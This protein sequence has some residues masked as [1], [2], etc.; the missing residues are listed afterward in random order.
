MTG[1]N[2]FG[3]TGLSGLGA[4]RGCPVVVSS[5]C[6]E[7]DLCL[8]F[9]TFRV[10]PP[11]PLGSADLFKELSERQPVPARC[12]E[13]GATR[14][15]LYRAST[16]C[17]SGSGAQLLKCRAFQTVEVAFAGRRPLQ[18]MHRHFKRC[19]RLSD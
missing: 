7:A 13:K 4:F 3:A 1:A 14:S 5:G 16:E 2:R 9:R 19:D 6:S 8:L 10:H 12:Q 11:L 17:A 18:D 15:R